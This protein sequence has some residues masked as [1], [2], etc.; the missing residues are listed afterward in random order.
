ML[1]CLWFRP[2]IRLVWQSNSYT[3]LDW[4][5][6]LS[7]TLFLCLAVFHPT[8]VFSPCFSQYRLGYSVV[9]SVPE[10]QWLKTSLSLSHATHLLLITWVSAHVIPIF[11][12]QVDRADSLWNTA[13][14]CGATATYGYKVRGG[15]THWLPRPPTENDAYHTAYLPLTSASHTTVLSSTRWL[16]QPEMMGTRLLW[17]EEAP[18]ICK[19]L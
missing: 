2:H 19:P 4:L 18:N 17:Q 16:H 12:T 1:F 13:G 3:S 10:S 14:H 9:K 5:R 15:E 8:R 11:G 6:L 7:Y